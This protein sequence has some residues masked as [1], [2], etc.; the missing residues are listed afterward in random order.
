[1]SGASPLILPGDVSAPDRAPVRSICRLVTGG[2]ELSKSWDMVQ[3]GEVPEELEVFFILWQD[4]A[5]G[6]FIQEG[7]YLSTSEPSPHLGC[8]PFVVYAVAIPIR[9]RTRAEC[10]RRAANLDLVELSKPFV[11]DPQ[12]RQIFDKF[13]RERGKDI[14]R[15]AKPEVLSDADYKDLQREFAAKAQEGRA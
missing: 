15:T 2:I 6:E 7:V 13:A 3:R 8:E 4:K 5:T 9:P 11:Y 12:Y 1:M 10:M 14:G